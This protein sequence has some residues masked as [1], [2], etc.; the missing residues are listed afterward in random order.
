MRVLEV[1]RHSLVRDHE[2]L[3]QAGVD[4]AR[5]VGAGAGPFDRVLTSH[6]TRTLETAIAMGFAVSCQLTVLGEIGPDV[7]AEVGHHERW[8]WADPFAAFARLVRSGGATARLGRAQAEAWR[9]IVRDLPDNGRALVIS[10]GRII[11]AGAVTCLPDADHATWGR[12]FD[13]CEGL[14]LT[15]DGDTWVGAELLRVSAEQ[16]EPSAESESTPLR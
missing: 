6:I 12:P 16:H 15:Y 5:R 3:S 2:H 14:R 1:R 9:A 11:E 4:L 10:H 7:W 13:K 8:E